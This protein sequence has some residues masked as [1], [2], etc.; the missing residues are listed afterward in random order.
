M[1][2]ML[3][4][5]VTAL[6]GCAMPATDVQ[7]PTRSMRESLEQARAGSKPPASAPPSGA[8]DAGARRTV[9]ATSPPG[10]PRATLAA[11][12]IRMAYLY[13][14]IDREGNQHFGTWV[15]IPLA[16]FDW[17]MNDGSVAPLKPTKLQPP[18]P[19][20]PGEALP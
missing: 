10:A 6:H 5:C 17:L 3:A 18:T 7:V 16:G 1:W 12:E 4:V 8:P 14:W 2:P 20:L 19:M 9:Q 15:A 13:D 11:P